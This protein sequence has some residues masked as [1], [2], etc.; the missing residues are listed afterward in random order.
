MMK[1]EETVNIPFQVES[2]ISNMLNNKENVYIRTNYK[3]R[4]L[5]IKD[6]IDKSIKKYDNE[7]YLSN[8]QGNRRTKG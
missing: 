1:K 2:L 7:L 5:S 6:A 4:L 8:V 3:N